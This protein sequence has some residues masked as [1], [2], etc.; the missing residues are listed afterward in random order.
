M[1]FWHAWQFEIYR[2]IIRTTFKWLY[3]NYKLS[4]MQYSQ[5]ICCIQSRQ[6]SSFSWFYLKKWFLP[7]IRVARITFHRINLLSRVARKGQGSGKTEMNKKQKVFRKCF[8]KKKTTRFS[9]DVSAFRRSLRVPSSTY[10][11]R[12]KIAF[13]NL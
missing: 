2:A 3:E 10:Q 8:K 13:P 5:S 1:K 4:E 6:C 11:K 7:P 12:R 9:E